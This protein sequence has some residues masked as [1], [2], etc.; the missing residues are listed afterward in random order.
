[1]DPSRT[2]ARDVRCGERQARDSSWWQANGLQGP[3][4]GTGS[5]AER[6]L[7]RESRTLLVGHRSATR[8]PVPISPWTAALRYRSRP[9]SP[10]ESTD[11]PRFARGFLISD[12]ALRPPVDDWVSVETA[13]LSISRAPEVP[14]TVAR[15][16]RH[17]VVVLGHLIDTETWA[18]TEA[19][20]T[21]AAEALA[22]SE[23]E[24]LDA[25]DAW[26]GRYLVLFGDGS[27]THVMTDASGMRSAFY[28]LEGPFVLASHA[29][30]AATATRAPKSSVVDAYRPSSIRARGA[31]S[32]PCRAVRR[33]G[34]GSSTSRRT[35]CWTSRRVGFDGSSR[36]VQRG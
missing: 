29:V 18:S 19:A 16:G 14:L 3:V 4:E 6:E 8:A 35:S 23:R 34:R 32:C 13:G 20:V 12:A 31:W 24:F 1:M 15:S 17:I 21:I 26:S 33:H 10:H 7:G 25:T 28:G 30:L 2:L 22:R 5:R 9:M 27:S 36:A 11:P